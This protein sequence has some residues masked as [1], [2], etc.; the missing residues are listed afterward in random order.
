M[1]QPQHL[2]VS[3]ANLE[4]F[5]AGIYE[6]PLKRTIIQA[7]FKNNIMC[8]D[9]AFEL[10]YSTYQKIPLRFDL[11]TSVP[12]SYWRSFAR[13]IDL[14]GSLAKQ[15]SRQTQIEFRTNVLK[16]GQKQKRQ[17]RLNSL[18]RAENMKNAFEAAPDVRGKT[19]LV[20]DDI[21]TTGNTIKA[22]YRALKRH[23]PAHIVFLTIAKTSF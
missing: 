15:L 7:K 2:Q 14:P 9:V 1:A 6:E 10:I 22:C 21:M 11:I 20:I 23:K 17:G 16:K 5:S 19:I 3:H 4:I 8:R 13:G 12:A 18:E